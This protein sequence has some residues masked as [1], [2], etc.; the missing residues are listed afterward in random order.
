MLGLNRRTSSR[1]G[2]GTGRPCSTCRASRG[3]LTALHRTDFEEL[4]AK[5]EQATSARET[6]LDDIARA[7]ADLATS[8]RAPSGGGLAGGFG[9]G[10]GAGAPAATPAD[11]AGSAVG[12]MTG[13]VHLDPADEALCTDC[14]TCYQELPQF[15]EKATVVIDGEATQIAR[16]IPG[17]V[18]RVEITPEIAKRIE[19]VKATC[20]A[21]I[22]R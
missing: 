7:M 10:L 5:Y 9:G 13:P 4:K 6:S 17:A 20:D 18:E 3:Q 2:A 16:M 14:G 11:S 21:E 12:V 19:R 22:I 8:S 15:F 1:T